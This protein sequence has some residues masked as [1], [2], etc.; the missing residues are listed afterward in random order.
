MVA[1]FELMGF[2]GIT[3]GLITFIGMKIVEY[4]E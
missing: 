1:I 2:V 3:S 4:K